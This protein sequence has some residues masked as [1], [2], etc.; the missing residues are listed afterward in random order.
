[1]ASRYNDKTSRSTIFLRL[2]NEIQEL[3]SKKKRLDKLHKL[4]LDNGYSAEGVNEELIETR[5][6]IFEIN[7]T[8]GI[9]EEGKPS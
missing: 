8:I 1:M 2:V 6:R 5:K 3:Q 7:R 9:E 4:M